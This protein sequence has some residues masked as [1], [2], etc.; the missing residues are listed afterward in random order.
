MLQQKHWTESI[1]PKGEERIVVVD[2]SWALLW[3]E[4]SW[5]GEREVEVVLIL[6]QEF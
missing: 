6:W 5:D 3:E 4:D 1:G 2:L